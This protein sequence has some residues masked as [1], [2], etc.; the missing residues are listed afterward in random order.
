MSTD[1]AHFCPLS[2]CSQLQQNSYRQ[3]FS[4]LQL[5]HRR[6]RVDGLLK[7]VVSQ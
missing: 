3:V 5:I 7:K 6:R 1:E 2:C 4:H